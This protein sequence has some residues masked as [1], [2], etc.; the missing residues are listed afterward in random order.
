MSERIGQP[1]A[2]AS[3]IVERSEAIAV[4]ERQRAN[5]PAQCRANAIGERS[6]AI[7]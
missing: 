3:A 6:E 2:T 1:S 5:R 4:S 7:A